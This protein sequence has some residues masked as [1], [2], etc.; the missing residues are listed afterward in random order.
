MTHC[1]CRSRARAGHQTV[2]G[3]VTPTCLHDRWGRVEATR[4]ALGEA[5]V[6][7]RR[8]RVRFPP[9]P[10]GGPGEMP[11]PLL[12][13][14]RRPPRMRWPPAFVS[15][16]CCPAHVGG[17]SARP[18]TACCSDPFVLPHAGANG[19]LLRR[20]GDART[21]VAG[22]DGRRARS[23]CGQVLTG[24]LD[25]ANWEPSTID[26]PGRGGARCARL[27]GHRR[28][29]ERRTLS[30]PALRARRALPPPRGPR[31]AGRSQACRGRPPGRRGTSPVGRC[32][33]RGTARPPPG[34]RRARPRDGR[35]PD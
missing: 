15:Y 23:R 10:P 33:D 26:R 25:I 6:M 2:T 21:Q 34:R 20:D 16:R 1:T 14:S 19:V 4:T 27:R 35:Q 7:R 17:Q 12:A 30:R 5:L 29:V 18:T 3:P 8:T 11:G 13:K 22:V 28:N 24:D 31:S 9:P 32:T